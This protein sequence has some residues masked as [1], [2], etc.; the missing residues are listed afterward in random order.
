MTTFFNEITNTIKFDS[1]DLFNVT[2]NNLEI[3]LHE[4]PGFQYFETTLSPNS[5][6]LAYF[7]WNLMED[8]DKTPFI[9][10]GMQIQEN[11]EFKINI[12]WKHL[13]NLLYLVNNE[14]FYNIL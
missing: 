9:V 10:Q 7:Q 4:S 14:N 3:T 11:T 8:S 2:L 1:H 5:K 6:H 13:Q 12:I